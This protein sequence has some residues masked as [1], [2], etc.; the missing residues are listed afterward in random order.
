MNDNS[1]VIRPYRETDQDAVL[2]INHASVSQ[3]SPL[4]ATRLHLLSQQSCLFWIAQR[5]V[6]VIALLLA[7]AP[8]SDYDS[9]N[10]RW[11]DQRY[12]G[13]IYVDRIVVSAAARGQGLGKRFYRAL[14]DWARDQG[15]ERIA[16]EVDIVPP[17]P[18]S[19]AF[20][21]GS[22]FVEVGQQEYG[23]P[24]KKV[25]LLLKELRADP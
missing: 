9:P 18:T 5:G 1:I 24:Q 23:Q 20:H 16:A 14:E 6:D 3:L 21:L 12:L 4:D 10:Y 7:F 8:G 11:F 15:L 17:N 2:A 19:L 22:G 25:A 13:F